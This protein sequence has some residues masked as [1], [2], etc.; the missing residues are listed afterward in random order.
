MDAANGATTKAT[1]DVT[2]KVTPDDPAAAAR[3]EGWTAGHVA[4]RSAVTPDGLV[5]ELQ[6]HGDALVAAL[7][8]G[9][10]Q[11]CDLPGWM[12]AAPVADLGL[13]EKLVIAPLIASF[14][15]LG[16]YPKPVLDIINPAVKA[17]LQHVGVTDPAP[18]TASGS[19]K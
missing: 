9:D 1:A 8:R 5:A 10:P 2:S 14:L 3:R 7:R 18:T 13:R 12:V 15:L 11:A 6:R 19:T 4:S 17:T 16:F